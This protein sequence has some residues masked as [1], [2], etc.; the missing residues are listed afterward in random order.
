MAQ[1]PKTYTVVKDG[2][3]QEVKVESEQDLRRYR[4]ELELVHQCGM[5]DPEMIKTVLAKKGDR[6]R[7]AGFESAEELEIFAKDPA[8]AES[9]AVIDHDFPD[10]PD[11]PIVDQ[12]AAPF[13]KDDA[14]EAEAQKEE[15]SLEDQLQGELDEL[16]QQA[17]TLAD[18][19]T[20]SKDH[21]TDE[22]EL[23]DSVTD[24]V[25]A[26]DQPAETPEPANEA[27]SQTD[28]L[29]PDEPAET[30]LPPPQADAD[31]GAVVD[32]TEAIK[33]TSQD[34]P[35]PAEV[36][37]PPPEPEADLEGLSE[38]FT[39]QTQ[40]PDEHPDTS[41]TD[42]TAVS[43]PAPVE[44]LPETPAIPAPAPISEVQRGP[45]ET[46]GDDIGRTLQSLAH[47]I[48]S[49]AGHLWK[50]A[51]D[52]L[53]EILKLRDQVRQAKQDAETWRGEAERSCIDARRASE[54]ANLCRN[55]AANFRE[56]A[57]CAKERAEERLREIENAADSAASTARQ[58]QAYAERAR[59]PL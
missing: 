51:K 46:A 6:I 30:E 21:D 37:Q 33:Q 5:G 10:L 12:E 20:E 17:A 42:V 31:I 58:A 24:A 19:L 38:L 26:T 53:E 56:D 22:P 39:E 44:Q 59:R 34:V 7:Q 41:Q 55:E 25:E 14:D 1:F 2:K 57:R 18:E 29:I 35:V 54:T 28:S 13:S 45:A 48:Q 47:L 11:S 3:L 27:A 23:T 32:T 36:E 49:E 52:A 9:V 16:A 40:A 43:Q 8:V 15:P 4:A 50:Q